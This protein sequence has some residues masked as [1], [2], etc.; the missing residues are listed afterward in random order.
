MSG[1]SQ[2]RRLKAV[3]AIVQWGDA[4]ACAIFAV[5]SFTFAFEAAAFYTAFG[6]DA[7]ANHQSTMKLSGTLYIAS[8]LQVLLLVVLAIRGLVL[9][10]SKPGQTGFW[11]SHFAQFL[12][13]SHALLPNGLITATWAA[14]VVRDS[15]DPHV[16]SSTAFGVAAGVNS[17]LQ[18]A[19]V[20]HTIAMAFSNAF[21]AYS[22]VVLFPNSEVEPSVLPGV[23][24]TAAAASTNHA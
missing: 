18:K 10:R 24:D 2:S 22:I 21:S 14:Q 11:K 12:V 17:H 23:G 15:M 8:S 5:F 9:R 16:G 4:V 13:A 6:K 1:E 19:Y 3:N 7:K 20:F